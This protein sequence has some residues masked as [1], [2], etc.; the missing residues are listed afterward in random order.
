MAFDEM[1]MRVMI[2]IFELAGQTIS[3]FLLKPNYDNLEKVKQTYYSEAKEIARQDEKK[4][5]KAMKTIT[6]PLERDEQIEQKM[7]L[8]EEKIEGGIACL[9][10]SR[11]HFSTVSGALNE[12]IRFSRREGVSHIEVKRR[13]GMSLDELNMLERIDLSPEETIKLKGKEKQLA[14]WGLNKSRELR[15]KITSIQKH[16]DLE[17]VAAEASKVRTEFMSKLWD[18]ITV[19]GSIKKLC[20]GLKDEEYERCVNTINTVLKEKEQIPP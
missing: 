18:V 10:C 15:H 17:K 6:R 2:G 12:A 19:D 14:D 13:L 4:R 11:D 5:D 1:K 20:V 3:G 16:E 8:S 9:P 7:D